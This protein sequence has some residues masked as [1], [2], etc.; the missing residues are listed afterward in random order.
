MA[1][2]ATVTLL[3]REYDEAL[4]YYTTILGFHV[5]RDTDMGS[6]RRFVVVAPNTAECSGAALLL[7]RASNE[8][9]IAAIGN[10]TGGRVAFFLEV[11]NFSAVYARYVAAGVVFIDEPRHEPYGTVAVFKDLYA[12]LWDL[13]EPKK[14]T[15]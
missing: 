12:N 11:E 13:I 14:S 1:R 9:Q 8:Q 2:L 4:L 10:Q 3:V 5:V 15:A 6:G 7:A